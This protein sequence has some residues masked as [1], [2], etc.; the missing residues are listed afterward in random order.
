MPTPHASVNYVEPNLFVGRTED[1]SSRG[2]IKWAL[3]DGYERAPRLEDYSIAVNIEVELSNRSVQTTS[4]S[5]TNTVYLLEWRSKGDTS[6]VN[7]MGGT[8]VATHDKANHYMNYLTTNYADMYVEDLVD[9]GTTELIG[10]KSI[11]IQYAKSCVPIVTIQFTDVRGLSLF[12]PTELSRTTTYNSI[13][14]LNADSIARSFFE[15][16]F[17]LPMP[18]FT[19]YIKGFYGKPVSY[20]VLCDKFETKFNSQTGDFDVVTRFIGYSYSFLTDISMDA[21]LAAPFSDYVGK[22]YWE[23]QVKD[24]FQLWN[25][26]KTARKPMPTLFEACMEI[27]EML[28]SGDT[29]GQDTT[30]SEEEISHTDEIATLTE[31]R[32]MYQSWYELLFNICKAYY[33]KKYCFLMKEAGDNGD[34]T[35]LLLLANANA[36]GSDMS[37]EYA[38]FPD[39][40]KKANSDL[41]AAVEKYNSSNKAYAQLQNVSPDMRDYTRIHLFNDIFINANNEYV[42]NGFSPDNTLNTTDVRNCVFNS[43]IQTNDTAARARNNE[44]QKK[45]ALQTIY[46]DGVNQFTDCFFIGPQYSDIKQ[47]INALQ[48]DA[49]KSVTEKEKEKKLKELND[50]MYSKMSWYP[51]VENF[52]RI[53]MAHLETLMYMMFQVVTATE[54]RTATSLGVTIGAEGTCSDVRADANGGIVP[55][56]PRV[57]SAVID[58]ENNSVKREDSWVGDFNN[59]TG[60]VEREMVDGLFNAVDE[61]QRIYK[62]SQ[63]TVAEIARAAGPEE[64]PIIKHP[65]APFDFALTGSPYGDAS[66]IANDIDFIE[67]AG[68]VAI[69]MF[70]L[71]TIN[72]LRW[73]LGD[74]WTSLVKSIGESEAENFHELVPITNRAILNKLLGEDM[75]S[76]QSII[77]A[78]TSID[79]SHPWGETR[80]FSTSKSNMWLDGYRVDYGDGTATW[81][82][83]LQGYT[84]AEMSEGVMKR[85]NDGKTSTEKGS[86]TIWNLHNG[87]QWP[88]LSKAVSDKNG[89][90]MTTKVFEDLSVITNVMNQANST[91]DEGG[92]TAIYDILNSMTQPTMGP[93]E[94]GTYLRCGGGPVSFVEKSKFAKIMTYTWTGDGVV[95]RNDKGEAY[96][97]TGTTNYLNGAVNGDITDMF[98]LEIFGFDY[99]NGLKRW[100][101]NRN[102]SYKVSYEKYRNNRLDYGDEARFYVMCIDVFDYQIL[103]HMF[104]T[105]TLTYVPKLAVLQ[106]GAILDAT[107]GASGLTID[108]VGKRVPCAEGIESLFEYLNTLSPM[109][110]AEYMRIFKEF[111]DKYTTTIKENLLSDSPP[112]QVYAFLNSKDT[113]RRFLREGSSY[114]HAL[115]NNVMKLVCAA[116][117][118]VNHFTNMQRGTFALP[119]GMATTYLQ[120]FIEK[121]K[122]LYGVTDETEDTQ[123]KITKT[124]SFTSKD[125]KK[126]LYRYLKQLYDKWIP[127]SSFEDWKME[128]FFDKSSEENG[129]TFYFID[130]FYNNIGDKLL[131]NPM[132][133]SEK[134]NAFMEYS[135]VNSMLL[136]FMADM[137][138][139]NKCMFLCLQNF[140]DLNKIGS[141]ADMFVPYSYEDAPMPNEYPSFVVVYPYEPSKNLDTADSEYNNDSFMLND[142]RET[143]IAITSKVVNEDTYLLP[144]FGV[145][146]GKQYQSFFK[147]VNVDMTAPVAT[148]QSI[149]AKHYIIRKANDDVKK[150]TIAQDMYDI[151]TTQSYTCKVEMLGCPWVQPM[152]YFVLLNIPMFRGSYM[153]MSVTHRITPGNMVT[154][155]TGCRMANIANSLVQNIFIGEDAMSIGST[156]PITAQNRLA[157]VSNDCPYKVYPLFDEGD[158]TQ[159]SN[160]TTTPALIERAKTYHAKLVEY[161]LKPNAAWG[162]MGNL[163]QESTLNPNAAF[164]RDGG[165]AG[166]AQWHANYHLFRDMYDNRYAD[167]GHW[168]QGNQTGLK[169][170]NAIKDL[171]KER[172]ADYQLR[173]IVNSMRQNKYP[174]YNGSP[175]NELWENENISISRAATIFCNHYEKPSATYA[176]LS[177]R[178]GYAQNF[179]KKAGGSTVST[180]TSS[181]ANTDIRQAFFTAVQK[182]VN[183]TPSIN[184]TLSR[185]NEGYFLY[186]WQENGGT[187]KL[188]KVFDVILNGYYE[189]VNTLVWIYGK[190]ALDKDPLNIAVIPSMS[191]QPNKRR[192]LVVEQGTAIKEVTNGTQTECEADVVYFGAGDATA[193]SRTLRES[194]Y[195]KYRG[196]NY[197]IPQFTD[198]AIFNDISIEDCDSL[199]KSTNAY[200][201]PSAGSNSLW[202]QTVRQMGEWFGNTV[203]TYSSTTFTSCSLLGGANVRHDCSGFV[204]ACLRLFGALQSD[205]SSEGLADLS[206][207]VAEALR[208]KGF[209]SCEY[210]WDAVQP[211]DII[212][213]GK[214]H[215]E[216]LADKGE[217]PRSYGWGSAHYHNMP[218]RADTGK[219]TGDYY[220]VIWR[221]V[222]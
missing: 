175:L 18:K 67:F 146:Y 140:F 82:Y 42:F 14:E 79:S 11:D 69:R 15:A 156:N 130:S 43:H 10:I 131:I 143:P 202:A 75:V 187:D 155:F 217:H 208:A 193:L 121:L 110:K 106:M 180:T 182:S 40:M 153:I 195:K 134:I 66:T 105:T 21:L 133:L 77:S 138:A 98:V 33:G 200:Q 30:L 199:M 41:Y 162:V 59:G 145:T 198:D 205:T 52:T 157:D 221:Y 83:P 53:M 76:P 97:Y 109:A 203:K 94:G 219:L 64:G 158:E 81:L 184:V 206:G 71:L 86:I 6:T 112:N 207:D 95:I 183:S 211:Y 120:A 178:I 70:N 60:F 32:M 218:A 194:L 78:V 5:N 215:T 91:S 101:L 122:K 186:I 34:Y 216:I 24:R 36:G 129:H 12:Q 142:E 177:D 51:S 201:I 55:P 104:Q 116:K 54:Q 188:G 124:P 17:K 119:Q 96:T 114:V 115:T 49:N 73:Q 213:K 45:Y 37:S 87:N 189:Y 181:N 19:I 147:N 192:V 126:E 92:Y 167:Y 103:A 8:K 9:Y 164:M 23:D 125:M 171:I 135:D 163:M 38:Q 160:V 27:N 139:Q 204:S 28:A 191:V 161:G 93:S 25:R 150:T 144:A 107:N 85:Y 220:Q 61:M 63:A 169:S 148:Q 179:A 108:I 197:E 132:K 58:S 102:S 89:G 47:R 209:K 20:Q 84:F 123:T 4:G 74:K 151:Y 26:E 46:N 111:S 137:Y 3:D 159:G 118:T 222:G 127:A 80:L 172:S 185:R 117:L 166:L 141:M 214:A 100:V 22:Q 50:H 44:R 1:T 29:D 149:K 128:S 16:F 170:R 2:Q 39:N 72:A 154:E 190:N 65:L 57:T 7:F 90:Y 68:R 99:D 136:G 212:V 62:E 152:M 196:T 113:E 56:F 165:S 88:V 13:T 176:Y 31:L 168:P 210:S 174:D 173:F 48:N 35:G